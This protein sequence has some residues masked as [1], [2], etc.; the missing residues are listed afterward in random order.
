[1]KKFFNVDT[2]EETFFSTEYLDDAAV[3]TVSSD[4]PLLNLK[5]KCS[6]L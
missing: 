6:L 3:A 5:K 2:C 1:V 4:L